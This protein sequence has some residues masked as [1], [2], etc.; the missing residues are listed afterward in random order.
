M[1]HIRNIIFIKNI[2]YLSYNN[3]LLLQSSSIYLNGTIFNNL[4]LQTNYDCNYNNI[5]KLEICNNCYISTFGGSNIKYFCGNSDISI[6]NGP[7]IN[8]P[9]STIEISERWVSENSSLIGG[10]NSYD[11]HN[12]NYS[13]TL[14]NSELNNLY[15]SS[16]KFDSYSGKIY[17][18]SFD[19]SLIMNGINNGKIIFSTISANT[20]NQY[21]IIDGIDFKSSLSFSNNQ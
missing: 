15:S 20:T 16:I 11:L 7:Y 10:N 5:N 1:K 18:Y 14:T 9:S 6:I 17:I 12:N 21:I 19:Q 8:S 2:T 3:I 13:M 4:F